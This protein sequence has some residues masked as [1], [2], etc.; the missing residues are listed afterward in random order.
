MNRIRRWLLGAWEYE[1]SQLRR[2]AATAEKD[3]SC[4]PCGSDFNKA[5]SR[6]AA[7]HAAAAEAYEHALAE[8]EAEPDEAYADGEG[9]FI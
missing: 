4:Y 2:R 7:A 3:A 9:E 6:L 5:L 8:V 1:A